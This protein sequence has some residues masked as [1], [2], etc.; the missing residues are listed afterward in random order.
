MA[1]VPC[2]RCS[3]PFY[4]SCHD[5]SCTT[6]ALCPFCAYDEPPGDDPVPGDDHTHPTPRRQGTGQQTFPA[7]P[8]PAR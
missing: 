3:Q 6:N 8:D 7:V 1:L 5:G 2:A 4:A